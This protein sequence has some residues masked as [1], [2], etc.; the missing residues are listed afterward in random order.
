MA[1][2]P[3]PSDS[4]S[5]P[6]SADRLWAEQLAM[7]L[8]LMLGL[9]IFMALY[10]PKVLSMGAKVLT[11]N[12]MPAYGWAAAVGVFLQLLINEAGTQVAAR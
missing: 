1:A 8:A 2:E 11:T 7:G 9:L 10:H 4:P 5:A 6:V 3:P 12:D